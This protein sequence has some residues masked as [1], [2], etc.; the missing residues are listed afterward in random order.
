MPREL[1]GKNLKEKPPTHLGALGK[2]PG[3]GL[4][5]GQRNIWGGKAT[6]IGETLWGAR[7]KTLGAQK[8]PGVGAPKTPPKRAKK[9][10]GRAFWGAERKRPPR[11]G[12]LGEI[13]DK[14]H[15]LGGPQPL[16]NGG[17]GAKKIGGGS[18][19]TLTQKKAGEISSR[20]RDPKKRGK[21]RGAI[22]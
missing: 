6:Q 13:R 7:K 4:W 11:G 8:T 10:K 9:K 12:P 3:I 1:S 18:H 5:E 17:G 19:K 22:Y 14:T 2:A 20:E 21:L 16:T 15:F